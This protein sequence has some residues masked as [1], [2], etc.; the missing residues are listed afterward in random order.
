VL[1]AAS[2][3]TI[4]AHWLFVVKAGELANILTVDA[5]IDTNFKPR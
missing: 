5:P 1:A 2:P 3:V 4:K